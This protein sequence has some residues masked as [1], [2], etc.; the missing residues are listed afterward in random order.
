MVHRAA[1]DRY[2][3]MR[4]ARC[5]RSGLDLPR[6]ALGL[7]QNFGE[8]R[9]L[10]SAREMMLRSAGRVSSAGARRPSEEPGRR[11]AGSR[12]REGGT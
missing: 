1:D 4:F 2:D 7:W 12:F 6:I 5:G 8:D 9:P 10:E 11:H 3:H